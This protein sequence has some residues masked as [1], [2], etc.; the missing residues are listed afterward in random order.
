MTL[1]LS[2]SPGDLKVGYSLTRN[3][4]GFCFLFYNI[5][6]IT[7]ILLLNEQV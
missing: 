1:I 7:K 4:P 3:S 5:C 6:S 2:T